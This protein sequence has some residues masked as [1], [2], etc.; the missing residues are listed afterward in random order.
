MYQDPSIDK[1]LRQT[2]ENLEAPTPDNA[3]ALFEQMRAAQGLDPD[4]PAAIDQHLFPHLEQIEVAFQPEHWTLME[5]RLKEE[6]RRRRRIWITKLAEVAVFLL[7]IGYLQGLLT[8][9]YKG[10]RYPAEAVATSETAAPQGGSGKHKGTNHH[11]AALVTANAV[12]DETA[13]VEQTFYGADQ[14]SVSEKLLDVLKQWFNPSDP[15]PAN[16]PA[17]VPLAP[18]LAPVAN[19]SGS[20]SLLDPLP[21]LKANGPIANAFVPNAPAQVA[22]Y[23]VHQRHL[24]A[25]VYAAYDRNTLSTGDER[26]LSEGLSAGAVVGYRKGKWGIESGLGWQRASFQPKRVIEIFDGNTTQGFYGSYADKVD[27][28]IISVPVKATRQ[29]ARVGKTRLHAV[30]GA[31]AHLAAFKNY[32]YKT[33]YFPGVLP[34]SDPN[35]QPSASPTLAQDGKGWLEQGGANGNFYLS[36]DA[37][38]RVEHP[39]NKRLIA[40]V[41]PVYRRALTR[42]GIGPGES[43]LHTMSIQAGVITTL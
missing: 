41:E 8:P 39:V 22:R 14:R 27:A 29:L 16:P 26:R 28:E 21:V 35:S 17:L 31:T 12:A 5:A 40:Y 23:A 30:G 42:Q 15:Q 19:A 18:G 33:V 2:L 32:E 37:G 24:Y 38:V 3:W 34:Q 7:L 43:R 20:K 11:N 25:G 36:A 13:P 4:Q 10:A 9:S 6:D 1:A